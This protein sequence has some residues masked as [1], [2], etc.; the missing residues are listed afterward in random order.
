[1]GKDVI[2]TEPLKFDDILILL[3]RWVLRSNS[4]V[5]QSIKKKFAYF[6]KQ[7]NFLY[8]VDS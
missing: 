3:L 5:F 4:Y 2:V 8:Q 7:A 6:L 1:M